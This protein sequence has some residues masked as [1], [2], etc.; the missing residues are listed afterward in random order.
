[1]QFYQLIRCD[2]I[3]INDEWKY[4]SYYLKSMFQTL[5]GTS[6]ENH[7]NICGDISSLIPEAGVMRFI[8]VFGRQSLVSFI[9]WYA[10]VKTLFSK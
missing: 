1:M 4:D 10:D 5:P 3:D 6:E 8:A 2:L 7:S 9:S